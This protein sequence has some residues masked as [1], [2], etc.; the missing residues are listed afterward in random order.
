MKMTRY[1]QNEDCQIP[2]MTACS[3]RMRMHTLDSGFFF[4]AA[5][6]GGRTYGWWLVANTPTTG[7]PSIFCS[8]KKEPCL[9]YESC[10]CLDQIPIFI[11]GVRIW[12]RLKIQAEN[13]YT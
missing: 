2:A 12:C 4:L 9:D 6:Y 5:K 10:K 11:S 3:L 8:Q 1:E 7:S 13:R